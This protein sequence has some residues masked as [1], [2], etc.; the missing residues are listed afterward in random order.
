MRQNVV[1]Q[2]LAR[3]AASLLAVLTLASVPVLAADRAQINFIGFDQ[4][5]KYF[6]FEQY[7]FHDGSGA[8]FSEI[9]IV[10]IAADKWV[11]G[12]PYI[13]DAV[14]D[15]DPEAKRLAQVRSEALAKAQSKLRELAIDWPTEILALNGDGARGDTQ[16]LSFW[17]PSCCSPNATQDTKFT[18][19]VNT[20]PMKTVSDECHGYVV[21]DEMVVGFTLQYTS[22]DGTIVAHKDGDAL[23]KSRGCTLNY[24]LYAVV[25]PAE[26]VGPRIA[27]VESWPF[28][29][30]GPDRRFIAVPLEGI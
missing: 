21:D 2:A 16:S 9:Y 5:A 12:V 8:A 20:M 28:G 4:D 19:T 14:R 11:Y 7:G 29:F 18:V 24:S 25:D 26:T 22:P 23:P 3:L 13:V 15:D 10:D 1:L 27:I 6:A 17:T 30:E